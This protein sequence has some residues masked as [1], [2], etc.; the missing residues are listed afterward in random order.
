MESRGVATGVPYVV[1]APVGGPRPDAPVVVAYHLLDAP[2]TE[3]ALA[4]PC[5]STV[6]TPAASTSD[7][8]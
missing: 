1:K 5:R 6:S 2:R 4:A 8:P 3:V 7:C